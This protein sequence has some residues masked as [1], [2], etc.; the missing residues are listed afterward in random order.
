MCYPRFNATLSV[1]CFLS[2]NA[3]APY[4]FNLASL[5]LAV[6]RPLLAVGPLTAVVLND[7]LD[8]T[9]HAALGSVCGDAEPAAVAR[10][11][12]AVVEATARATPQGPGGQ[13]PGRSARAAHMLATLT[14][15]GAS[16]EC[17]AAEYVAE[18]FDELAATFERKLV[19]HLGYKVNTAPTTPTAQAAGCARARGRK[20]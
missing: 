9:A 15:V 6:G 20:T 5:L 10:A 16:A 2:P 3:V 19:G 8:A 7:P 18:V 11:Y 14:G 4:R 12:A 1:L 13:G 17:A